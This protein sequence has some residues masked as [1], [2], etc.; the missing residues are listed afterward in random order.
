VELSYSFATYYLKKIDL[1]PKK[2]L[3]LEKPTKGKKMTREEYEDWTRNN[4]PKSFGS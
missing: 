2:K 1:D 3:K 4:M